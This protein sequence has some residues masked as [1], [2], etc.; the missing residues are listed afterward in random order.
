MDMPAWKSRDCEDAQ[1]SN[2]WNTTFL[3]RKRSVGFF[4]VI[5]HLQDCHL[6]P[7][8][9]WHEAWRNLSKKKHYATSRLA[10]RVRV[11]Q[12]YRKPRRLMCA[13]RSQRPLVFRSAP[14][15]MRW[16][17]LRTAIRKSCERCA[18]ARSKLIGPGN[19][20]KNHASASAR[21]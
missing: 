4:F 12:N 6:S 3:K 15:A 5:A 2:A 8:S 17:C 13:R 21:I 16:K 9:P 19:G 1:L 7:G 11:R 14:S 10:V 20:P 18:T